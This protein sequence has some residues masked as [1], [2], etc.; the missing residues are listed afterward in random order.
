MMIKDAHEEQNDAMVKDVFSSLY[1]TVVSDHVEKK[2]TGKG[3][4][5]LSYLSWAWAWKEIAQRYPDVQY[6]IIMNENNLP[7]F[8]DDTGIMVYTKMTINGITRMMWLPVM[9]STNTALKMQPYTITTKFGEKTVQAATM[10]DI[11]KTVMRCLVK[12]MA[13]FGLGLSLYAGEDLPEFTADTKIAMADLIQQIHEKV[14]AITKTMEKA[15][16]QKFAETCIIPIIGQPDYRK[17][18]DIEKL[19]LLNNKLVEYQKPASDSN[20]A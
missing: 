3:N 17:C 6:E 2:P 12:N 11:N 1:N 20:A 7:Y 18:I 10:T 5:E 8:A 13:M 15:E 19:T 16:K 4:K 9:D 14:T